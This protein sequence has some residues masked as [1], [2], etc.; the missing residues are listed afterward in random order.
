MPGAWQPWIFLPR[1]NSLSAIRHY[2]AMACEMRQT[3]YTAR[4]EFISE[5]LNGEILFGV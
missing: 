2:A 5:P 1:F 4:L 3:V